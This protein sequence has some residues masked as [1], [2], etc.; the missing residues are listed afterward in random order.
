LSANHNNYNDQYCRHDPARLCDD[1]CFYRRILSIVGKKYTLN[2]LR[3]LFH[4]G[5]ARFNTL[6]KGIGGSPKTLTERLNEL[7]DLKIIKREA[8]A[9]IPPRVEYS[10][11]ERG[12]DLE[13]VMTAIRSWAEKW[14]IDSGVSAPVME[15]K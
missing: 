1:R 13:P 14:W 11:T 6:A 10:L 15:S 7:V 8:F 4:K 12:Y 5:S 9:E 2:I 3:I